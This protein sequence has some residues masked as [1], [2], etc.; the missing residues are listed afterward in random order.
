MILTTFA[1][2][3]YASDMWSVEYWLQTTCARDRETAAGFY[4]APRVRKLPVNQS[5][6]ASL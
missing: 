4:R 5:R 2:S 1:N 3:G 6:T